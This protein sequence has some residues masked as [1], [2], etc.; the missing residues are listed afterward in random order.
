M[1]PGCNIQRTW[2]DTFGKEDRRPNQPPVDRLDPVTPHEQLTTVH[3]TR[4]GENLNMAQKVIHHLVDDLDGSEADE[5]VPFALDGVE[6]QIDLTSDH[7]TELRER[8]AAYVEHAR[9]TGGRLRPRGTSATAKSGNGPDPSAV[10]EWAR[11]QGMTVSD[12]GRIAVG[13]M[14][15]YERA[16]N[17]PPKST[18]RKRPKRKAR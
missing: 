4:N 15:A 17:E 18:E 10:R 3:P 13:V 2:S 14:E 7:A 1:E 11:K 9:R 6:Y 12:R 5:T 8:L 16:Q